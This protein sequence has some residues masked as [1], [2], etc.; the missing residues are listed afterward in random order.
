MIHSFLLV[1]QS[2][3]AG[4]G[5][6]SEVPPIDNRRIKL[7][8]NGMWRMAFVPYHWDTD[9]AGICM[10]ESFADSYKKD[11]PD[12]QV[13]LIPAAEGGTYLD[14]WMPGQPLY[15]SAVFQAKQAMRDSELKAILWHQGESDCKNDRYPYYEEKCTYILTSL[16]KELGVDV[17]IIV[18]GLGDFLPQCEEDPELVNYPHINAALQAM[19]SKNDGFYYVSA[20]GLTAN[21]DQLHFNAASLRELGLRYYEVVKNIK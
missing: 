13:G 8:K 3:M 17:P 16:R 11:N 20:Q 2:N 10:A 4:R 9:T 14:Q 21:A 18:G 19:V 12:V 15:E 6:V 1:G 5:I 7:I